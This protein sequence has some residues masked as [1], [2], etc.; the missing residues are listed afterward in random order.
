M[1]VLK[2]KANAAESNILGLSTDAS[3]ELE[4]PKADAYKAV[5][6]QL[7][8]LKTMSKSG[9]LLTLAK[10]ST[11][12]DSA[13]TAAD[14]EAMNV[15]QRRALAESV[16][17]QVEQIAR[18]SRG[19]QATVTGAAVRGDNTGAQQVDELRSINRGINRLNRTME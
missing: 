16:G 10:A 13:Q 19:Q 4:A 2:Q 9:P 11:L 15:V 3:S 18:L 1:T 12:F 7:A 8:N 17:L 14:F 6:K 5:S